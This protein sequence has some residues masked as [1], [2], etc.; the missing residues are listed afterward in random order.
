MSKE[1]AHVPIEVTESEFG[2]KYRT[3][4]RILAEQLRVA[5][6]NS[7]IAL[8]LERVDYAFYAKYSR[9]ENPLLTPLRKIYKGIKESNQLVIQ[10]LGEQPLP[11]PVRT[12]ER[13]Y[14]YTGKRSVKRYNFIAAQHLDRASSVV[15]DLQG[16]ISYSVIQIRGENTTLPTTSELQKHGDN[17]SSCAS[18]LKET[19]ITLNKFTGERIT[20][21]ILDDCPVPIYR[22]STNFYVRNTDKVKLIEYLPS[23]H[24]QE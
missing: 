14:E 21:Y 3:A 15:Q 9:G 23:K 17:F 4:N 18:V 20:N 8:L 24:S 1:D 6:S 5:T 11:I 2:E 22:L 19:G 16:R 7:E 12:L 13:T 10:S